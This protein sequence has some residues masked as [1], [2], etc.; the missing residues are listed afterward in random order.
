L[1]RG[2]EIRS[3]LLRG[4]PLLPQL[5]ILLKTGFRPVGC[6]AAV[7]GHSSGKGEGVSVLGRFSG[8]TSGTTAFVLSGS[9]TLPKNV[10]I[11]LAFCL[12][13]CHWSCAQNPVNLKR[14]L[15]QLEKGCPRQRLGSW[16]WKPF[17]NPYSS[18]VSCNTPFMSVYLSV[19]FLQILS[20]RTSAKVLGCNLERS[21]RR[22]QQSNQPPDFHNLKFFSTATLFGSRFG[23][24]LIL[25]LDCHLVVFG[26]VGFSSRL[27]CPHTHT[28]TNQ[29]WNNFTPSFPK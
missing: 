11:F 27:N 24:P 26:Y 21:A 19:R 5:L 17:F 6:F 4:D 28:H 2:S 13:L 3:A 12:Y 8:R 1:L 23:I 10:V 29:Q 20:E 9:L 16:V 25:F 18:T 7:L 22:T 14:G 15:G